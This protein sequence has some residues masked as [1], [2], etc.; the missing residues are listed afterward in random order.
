MNE[1]SHNG[2][3]EIK[4]QVSLIPKFMGSHYPHWNLTE[5]RKSDPLHHDQAPPTSPFESIHNIHVLGTVLLLPM[6][7]LSARNSYLPCKLRLHFILQN[8]SQG[9]HSIHWLWC[10]QSGLTAISRGFSWAQD[11]GFREWQKPHCNSAQEK[12][13]WKSEQAGLF[14]VLGQPSFFCRYLW[15]NNT[16]NNLCAGQDMDNK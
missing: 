1:K 15:A 16:T 11:T 2:R 13:S 14:L 10:K 4:T 5:N 7:S 6:S 8:Y 12:N 9:K 3:D